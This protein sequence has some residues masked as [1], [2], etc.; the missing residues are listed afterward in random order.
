MFSYTTLAFLSDEAVEV[1]CQ[2]ICL[3]CCYKAFQFINRLTWST[4]DTMKVKQG[5]PHFVAMCKAVLLDDIFANLGNIGISKAARTEKNRKPKYEHRQHEMAKK[6]V[7]LVPLIEEENGCFSPPPGLRLRGL[8]SVH[9]HADTVYNEERMAS[10]L[11]PDEH[12]LQLHNKIWT[13]SFNSNIANILTQVLD[14]ISGMV[15]LNVDHVVKGGSL[16]K[17]VAI[18]GV[19]RTEA[20]FFLKGMPLVNQRRWLPALL[21]ATANILRD[22]LANTDKGVEDVYE[23]DDYCVQVRVQGDLIVDIRFSPLFDS[24][25]TVIKA[26]THQDESAH[27]YYRASLMKQTILF[28]AQQPEEVKMT[29]RLVKWWRDQQEWSSNMTYPSDELLELVVI[30]SAWQEQPLDQRAAMKKVMSLLECFDELRVVWPMHYSENDIWPSLLNQRPLLMDPA[31]P[32]VNA[33]DPKFFDPCELMAFA[34][35]M[36]PMEYF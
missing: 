16:G 1:L 13:E 5:I 17:G 14:T 33:A 3:V 30:Y 25:Q 12:Y 26:L 29:M 6:E 35:S 22:G 11:A 32:F 8:P 9:A 20:V 23:T 15:F 31:N 34:W 19:T 36:R 27:E 28:V 4:K 21:R 7:E 24:T 18:S 2:F 10:A